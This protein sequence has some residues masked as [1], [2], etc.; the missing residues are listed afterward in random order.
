MRKKPIIWVLVGLSAMTLWMSYLVT[1][2]AEYDFLQEYHPGERHIYAPNWSTPG[3]L[4]HPTWIHR[5]YFRTAFS[6]VQ[7]RI[8][9]KWQKD[10]GHAPRE[11]INFFITPMGER[12]ML[13]GSEQDST[14][15]IEEDTPSWVDRQ[16]SAVKAWLHI[17]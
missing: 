4:P 6:Q 8:E 11:N 9:L 16:A 14:L 13:R 2:P 12:A 3:V 7:N 1:R 15:Y 5:F 10:H 17:R